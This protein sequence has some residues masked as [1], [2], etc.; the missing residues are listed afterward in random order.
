MAVPGGGA[1]FYQRG[2]PVQWESFQNKVLNPLQAPDSAQQADCMY[3]VLR[4]ICAYHFWDC[5][6]SYS[7]KIYNSVWSA[8]FLGLWERVEG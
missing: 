4:G 5:D 3:A 7:D 1:V 2:T 6:A 8:P